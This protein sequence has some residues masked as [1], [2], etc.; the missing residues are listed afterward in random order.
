MI[1]KKNTENTTK[2]SHCG[3][4]SEYNLIK[5]PPKE[6]KKNNLFIEYICLNGHEFVIETKLKHK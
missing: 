5:W 1:T 6:D 4:I 2:C 3:A